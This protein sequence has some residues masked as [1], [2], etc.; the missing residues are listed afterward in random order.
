M[1]L[2]QEKEGILIAVC[3][4]QRKENLFLCCLIFYFYRK[5]NFDRRN[6]DMMNIHA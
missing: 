5:E 4:L 6:G 3:C 2:I 1:F